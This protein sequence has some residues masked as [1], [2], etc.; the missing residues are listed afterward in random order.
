[1]PSISDWNVSHSLTN[2]LKGGRAQMDMEPTRKKRPVTGITFM[3]PPIFSMSFVPVPSRT[4]PAPMNKSAL[5][6]PW[7]SVW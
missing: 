2:P 5:N 7:L 6:T 4:E 3:R 1:V